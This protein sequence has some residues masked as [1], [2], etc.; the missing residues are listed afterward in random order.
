M[1]RTTTRAPGARQSPGKSLKDGRPI[2]I[3]AT[4]AETASA[5]DAALD[6]LTSA[7]RCVEVRAD[8]TGDIDPGRIRRRFAGALLYTL[9]SVAEGGGCDDPPQRRRER[10]IAAAEHYDYVDLEAARDLHPDVLDAITPSRR[11]LSWHGRTVD[12]TDLRR[13]FDRLA[14]VEAHL[15]RLAPQAETQAQALLPLLLLKSLG[16]ADVMAYAH[17]P[18]GTW[19]RVLTA[20]FGAPVAFGRLDPAAAGGTGPPPDGELPLRRLLADYPDQ[21]LFD[22]E[23][24]YGIIGASTTMSLAS[25]VQNISYRSLGLPELSLPFSTDEFGCALAELGAG[26]DELGLPLAAATVVAPYKEAALSL[27]AEASPLARVAGAASLLV[28][29]GSEWW[30]DNEAAGV[31]DALNANQVDVAGRRIAV[32]GCGGGGRAAAAGLTQAGAEVTLVNRGLSRGE[33]AANLLD[34]PFV[35]LSDFDP[36]PFSVLVHAA[37][38]TDDMPFPIDGLDPEAVIFDLNYRAGD[39]RLIAAARAAG[40]VTVDGRDMLLAELSRRFLLVN[41]RHMPVA[42]VRAALG[43]PEKAGR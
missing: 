33:W 17:G 16:R 19:T 18:A 12:L 1:D 27:A 41:G 3:V 8:L 37:P 36:R 35:L 42:D 6:R 24:L 14:Q 9:R 28:R 5:S 38:V 29:K 31:V 30:A 40:H 32:V 43:I 26:L 20:R 13:R 22:A 21:L 25:L 11:V 10:L 23:R 2:S 15:Y 39:S 34:L 4:L 7:V